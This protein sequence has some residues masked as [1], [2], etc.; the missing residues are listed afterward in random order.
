MGH[1]GLSI[2]AFVADA[3]DVN[4]ILSK[5]NRILNN[6][7]VGE[8]EREREGGGRERRERR[9]KGGVGGKE[10]RRATLR[11]GRNALIICVT[12]RLDCCRGVVSV[13]QV[14]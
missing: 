8:R 10:D 6:S 4:N 3:S 13:E 14:I 5:S 7:T 12:I 9:E 11:A 2:S 1:V